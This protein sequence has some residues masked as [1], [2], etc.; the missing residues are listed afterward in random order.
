MGRNGS[1]EHG[2]S[3]VRLELVGADSLE[4]EAALA[5]LLRQQRSNGCATWLSRS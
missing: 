4:A 5:R 1:C 3:E 2:C